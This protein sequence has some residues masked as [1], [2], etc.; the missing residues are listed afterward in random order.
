MKKVRVNL[1]SKT[2]RNIQVGIDCLNWL[3]DNTRYNG[4]MLTEE[5]IKLIHTKLAVGV[6]ALLDY[7]E[8]FGERIEE[9]K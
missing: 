3:Q 1:S 6:T 8:E 9:N 4:M 5:E 2:F 7:A